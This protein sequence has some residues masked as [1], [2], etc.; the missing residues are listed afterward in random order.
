MAVG[1]QNMVGGVSIQQK[2]TVAGMA[3]FAGTGPNG[4]T[5]KDCGFLKS[6]DR[7]KS[8]A[9]DRIV[10]NCLKFKELTRRNVELETPYASC[11]KYFEEKPQT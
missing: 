4:K 11:C 7:T 2:E 3:H 10:Y 8:S 6:K 1:N 9:F 5:C